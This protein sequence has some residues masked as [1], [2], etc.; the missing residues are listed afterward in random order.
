MTFDSPHGSI[1]YDICGPDD[2]P[3]VVF[4]PGI[5]MDLAAFAPQAQGLEH[6]FRI[7]RWDLPG[8]GESFALGERKF[9]FALATDCL[10]G[11]LDELNI[12]TAAFVGVS[13]GSLIN[14][15]VAH[16]HGERVFA[17]IDVGG[18]P[19][20]EPMGR[21]ATLVWR[22]FNKVGTAIPEK[23]YYELFAKER[24]ITEETRQYLE[25][26][27][28]KVGKSKVSRLTS[29]FLTDQAQ[30]IPAPP[31][32][33]L[34]IINGEEEMSFVQKRSEKWHASI[35]DSQRIEIPGAG[36]I[37]NLDNAAAFNE[38]LHTYLGQFEDRSLS[39]SESRQP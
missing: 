15:Y 18:L 3:V 5:T 20:H 14:Q 27:I 28:A 22:L 1:H 32:T 36:H 35:A 6:N 8:H 17:L 37:A 23:K 11:L 24:A 39:G 26:G 25:E 13:L 29:E 7:L 4:T 33:P 10:I 30:G 19:L 16:H 12:D 9:S 34:L 38:A 2:A 31:D 21:I